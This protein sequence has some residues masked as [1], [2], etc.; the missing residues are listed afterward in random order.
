MDRLS[1]HS[2]V[3][4]AVAVVVILVM[5]IVPV[6][7][8]VLDV[9]LTFNIT[10]SLVVLLVTMYTRDALDFSSFPSLLLVATLF[11]LALNVSSTRLILLHGYAG[12]VIEAF[13]NFVVG[14][15]YV[16]GMV[17]FIILVVIQFVVITNGAGRV[18]EVAA[19]FTLD[20]MPGKQMSIDADLNA[21]LIDEHTA[22]ARRRAI[23]LE[24]DFYGA[25]DGAS[26][27]VRGDAIAGIIITLVNIL[28]GI[29]IGM[30]QLR[31]PVMQA[32]QTFALLTVGDGLVSQIP[33]LLISTA[34][35]II[36][37][38]AAAQSNFGQEVTTQLLAQPR[39]VAIAAGMLVL[40][41]LVPGLPKVPFFLIAA[42]AG[43]LSYAMTG[44]ERARAKAEEEAEKAPPAPKQPE[45][46]MSLLAVDPL[47]LEIGYGLVPLA[48]ES[49]GGNLLERV[50]MV[51]RQVAVDLGLVLPHIRIR[52]NI[53]LRPS[54]YAIKIRGVEVARGEVMMGYYLAMNPGIVVEPVP[55]IETTEPAFGLPAL[56]IPEQDRER[57]EMAGYTVVD[58]TSVIVTHLTEVIR[59]HAAEILSRQDTAN[60]IDNVK[61]TE[62]AV[63]EELIP[64]LMTVGEV[65]KVLQNLLREG[66]PI[67]NVATILEALGDHARETRDVDVL[68]EHARAALARVICRQYRNA[69]GELVVSTV[70]P[71]IE[72]EIARSIEGRGAGEAPALEPGLVQSIVRAVSRAVEGMASEGY[73]PILLTR[74]EVRPY[75]RR[76]VERVLPD[77]V[78][79]SYN[80]IAR[81]QKVRS[82]GTVRLNEN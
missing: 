55:G 43:A 33:A 48:D 51:R 64:N 23:E 45:N 73:Q 27:F 8:F 52:D 41:G 38:R 6:P 63:V 79:L 71:E 77:V 40:F 69:D 82:V 14:G 67:R 19:R 32:L 72:E 57:A 42:A 20:A 30:V 28:G 80:E 47:E 13:G 15:N 34:T 18:A 7:T 75:L 21:G 59:R 10:F 1:K 31:M 53:Q 76:I 35:G 3:L 2:D 16:V 5:M 58:P 37:T 25:M 9:L 17:V 22:R 61:K 66:V 62:P 50:T 29:I 24:A 68:T 26:K 4:V 12:K 70:D 56:W 46:V 36:V 49:E 65:Q 81:D 74:P 11:R 44:A 54:G 78:V 60:L 39:A